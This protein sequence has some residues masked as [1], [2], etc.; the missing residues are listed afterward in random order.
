MLIYCSK[1]ELFIVSNVF[2]ADLNTWIIVIIKLKCIL[3]IPEKK[4]KII[5]IHFE[6]YNLCKFFKR[7][8][9]STEY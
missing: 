2:S 7:F 9:K 4:K 3:K 6:Y 8:S 5:N 1:Q